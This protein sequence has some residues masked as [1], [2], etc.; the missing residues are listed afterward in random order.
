MNALDG[1]LFSEIFGAWVEG[2]RE[3]EPDIICRSLDL[4]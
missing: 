1:D 3:D 2:L 4:I